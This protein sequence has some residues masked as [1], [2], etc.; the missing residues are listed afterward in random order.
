MEVVSWGSPRAYMLRNFLSDAECDHL[1][2]LAEGRLEAST[3]VDSSTGASVSDQVR[4]SFGMFLK[5]DHDATVSKVEERLASI[6]Q[7]P[8]RNGEGV[9][10][11]RYENGQKYEPHNDYFYD[12]VNSATA[13]GGQRV[14][15]VLTYLTTPVEGGE[16]IFPAAAA[17]GSTSG[18]EWSDC[19]RG[20]LA[21]KATR[22]DA[23]LF[24]S[25]APDGTIDPMSLHGS[26]PTLRGTKYSM[27]KWSHIYPFHEQGPE[28]RN[29][30]DYS[31]CGDRHPECEAYRQAGR[32][33]QHPGPMNYFC[34]ES[35]DRCAPAMEGGVP[36]L[37][38]HKDEDIFEL[39]EKKFPLPEDSS[40]TKSVTNSDYN[41]GDYS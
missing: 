24:Y 23:L 38:L 21:V 17:D 36:T 4:T 7:V 39:Y 29:F 31:E 33:I 2:G 25:L 40:D 14:A 10:I 41:G 12:T 11:L 20:L 30:G 26:C 37:Q 22:G 5:R 32:C 27:T 3:V 9:Q 6:T 1:I 28:R 35:C 18:P 19:A 8:A 13:V 15:T 16:T 34:P